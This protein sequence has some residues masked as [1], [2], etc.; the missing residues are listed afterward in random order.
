M[1]EDQGIEKRLSE[2]LAMRGMGLHRTFTQYPPLILV[3]H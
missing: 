3:D 1:R 2:P